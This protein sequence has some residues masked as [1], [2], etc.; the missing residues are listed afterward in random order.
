MSRVANKYQIDMC[1]GGI[2]G[3][4]LVFAIPLM[5]SSI[6]QLLFNAADVVVVGRFA[7]DNSLAAVG[8][9]SSLVNLLTNVFLGL[10]VGANVC[11]ARYQGAGRD[12]EV[13]RT[14]HTALTLAVLS[15]FILTLIGVFGARIILTWMSSPREVIDLS[16]LY[17]RIFFIGMIPNM[18]YNFGAAILRSIGDTRRPLYYLFAAGIINVVLNLIFVIVFSMDVAGVALATI[19]SQTI[20]AV[21]VIRCLMKEQGSIRF[22][23]RKMSI[24]R[25]IVKDI[26]RIGLP[27]GFQGLL[28]SLSNVI[29]Q[30]SVNSFGATVVAANSAA[31]SI[32]GFVWVSMNAFHQ[33]AITFTGQNFGAG[34]ISRI[35]LVVR[36]ALICVT[37][38]G[39]ILGRSAYFFG[40]QLMGIYTSNPDVALLG[41]ERIKWVCGLYFLCGV[42][43]VMVGVL[44]GLG[45]SVMPMIVSLIGACGLR[46]IWIFTLFQIERFHEPKYLY[47]TYPVSW[48]VTFLFHVICFCVIWRRT[49]RKFM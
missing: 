9:T 45:Y 43:D 39:L 40:L 4:M 31:A 46:I 14:V 44:R 47:V 18:L 11:V 15:G 2:V 48:A 30:S 42:M 3:K 10:S 24:D 37:L 1:S 20:S 16:A 32:E 12:G 23:P 36:D 19:I 38:T 21:M 13:S 49:K 22:E 35:P 27:S 33:A 28:F 8:S 7:G 5:L 41:L 6:L 26:L 25:D 34:K 29:I 17:L